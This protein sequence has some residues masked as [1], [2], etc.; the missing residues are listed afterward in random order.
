HLRADEDAR[1]G[2]I[3]LIE[4]RVA[5]A[6]AARA[7]T[8]DAHHGHL[9]EALLEDFLEALG[10]LALWRQRRAGAGRAGARHALL[11][12]AVM[13]TQ[14]RR[15]AVQGQRPVTTRAVRTP[16]AGMAEQHRRVTA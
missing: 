15:A 10:A 12:T 11:G 7:V 8:I 3:E 4:D 13:A 9:R 1:A 2:D 5:T 14:A 6:S 16:A